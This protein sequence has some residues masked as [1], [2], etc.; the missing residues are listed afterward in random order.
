MTNIVVGVDGGAS[1]TRV[2]VADATGAE[3]A[4]V[5]GVASAV[6]P[7]EA[8]HSAEVIARLVGEG[9][10][11]ARAV[12]RA[13]RAFL[14]KLAARLLTIESIDGDELRELL[15]GAHV[16]PEIVPEP[17]PLRRER[18]S[19]GSGPP[20]PARIAPKGPRVTIWPGPPGVLPGVLPKPCAAARPRQQRPW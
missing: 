17:V 9:L 18:G 5:T 11:R 12:V 6:R 20:W 15:R 19:P 16:P 8:A 1:K 7:G 2:I 10:D 3:L 4:T 13:N 14:D